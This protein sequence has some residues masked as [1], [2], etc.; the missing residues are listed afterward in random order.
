[1]NILMFILFQRQYIFVHDC[2]LEH[3]NFGDTNIPIRGFH[4]RLEALKA[5]NAVT[6]KSRLR[7]EFEVWLCQELLVIAEKIAMSYLEGVLFLRP[8]HVRRSE[9]PGNSGIGGLGAWVEGIGVCSPCK[10]H[11]C[12]R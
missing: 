1:M 12:D 4:K 5:V 11:H 7:E 10:H 2:I 9:V 8:S 6:K 3:I